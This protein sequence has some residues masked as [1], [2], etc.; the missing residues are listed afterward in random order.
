VSRWQDEIYHLLNET[1]GGLI[2]RTSIDGMTQSSISQLADPGPYPFLPTAPIRDSDGVLYLL[3]NIGV[4]YVIDE[5]N[6]A[7]AVISI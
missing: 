7:R 5:D 3:D 4:I 6:G 1:A 2:G